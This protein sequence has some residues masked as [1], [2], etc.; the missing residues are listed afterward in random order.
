MRDRRQFLKR[1]LAGSGGLA[2]T[3]SAGF[4]A[5]SQPVQNVDVYED[6]GVY[7]VRG[8]ID[9]LEMRSARTADE[10][11]QFAVDRLGKNGGAVLLQCGTFRLAKQVNLASRVSLRGSGTGTAL[12]IEETHDTGIAVMANQA[13]GVTVSDLAI[14]AAK[15]TRSAKAGVVIDNSGSCSVR[16]VFCLGLREHGIW[17]RNNAFLCE[18]SGCKLA[19]IGKSGI[20]L[21]MLFRSGRGGDYVPNLVANCIVYAGGIGIE[22]SRAIV[23]NIMGCE[24]FESGGYGFCVRNTSNSVLISGCRTFQIRDD[25]VMIDT[26]DEINISSNVFCWHEGHGVVLKKVTWGT[27]TGNE[28][29]DTGSVNKD[30]EG[31]KLPAGFPYKNGIYLHSGT[32][33]IS[34]TG[35][36]I[37]NWPV[38]PPMAHGILE[39]VTCQKN[40]I[41]SNNVNFCKTDVSSLGRDSKAANNVSYLPEP[42]RQRKPTVRLQTFDVAVIRRF[43]DQLR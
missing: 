23:A 9:G 1:T 37:F 41:T 33:G 38:A 25:A 22:C 42:F 11:I 12:W 40:V 21:E 20:F 39:D 3:G 5:A 13:D 27:I 14:K 36:S 10:A 28:V 18:V 26:S 2:F 6:G 34:V 29:I 24:V 4:A 43:I 17:L 31:F 19:D 32:R 7:K 15:N 35:N 8:H 16:N 30:L